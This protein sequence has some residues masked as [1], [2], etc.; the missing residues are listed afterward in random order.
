MTF[1]NHLQPKE[2]RQRVVEQ[3][4]LNLAGNKFIGMS[5]ECEAV[6]I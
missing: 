6:Y 5:A 1:K 3:K 2:E 4:V